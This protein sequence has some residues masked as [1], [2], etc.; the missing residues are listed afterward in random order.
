MGRLLK[1][2]YRFMEYLAA[3]FLKKEG[4]D[5]FRVA[6]LIILM[7]IDAE[8]GIMINSLSIRC[9]VTKQAISKIIKEL[10]EEGYV[11]TEK[12]P[13]DARAMLAKITDKGAQFMLVWK[14]CTEHI[15]EQFKDIIGSKRLELL[16]DILEEVVEHFETNVSKIDI[17]ESMLKHS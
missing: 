14:R 7:N 10:Q 6:H 5:N 12:H 3:D 11:S 8:E 2:S 16:K 13:T 4:Y 17:D 9:G 15:D 1:K